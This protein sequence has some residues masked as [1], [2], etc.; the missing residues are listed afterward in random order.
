MA[1]GA[2]DRDDAGSWSRYVA[3]P[4]ARPAFAERHLVVVETV[5]I[6][7]ERQ[8]RG[9]RALKIRLGLEFVAGERIDRIAAEGALAAHILLIENR[10]SGRVSGSGTDRDS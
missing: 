6:A 10:R 3:V 5:V 7:R 2:R 4:V 9:W 1:V 8:M